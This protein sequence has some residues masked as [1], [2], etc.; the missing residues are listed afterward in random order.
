MREITWIS[1]GTCLPF[2]QQWN[3][4][5]GASSRTPKYGC[6]RIFHVH[7]DIAIILIHLCICLQWHSKKSSLSITGLVCALEWDSFNINPLKLNREEEQ[8]AQRRKTTRHARI[9]QYLLLQFLSLAW[10][11]ES[12]T[13]PSF[14]SNQSEWDGMDSTP[15]WQNWA[16]PNPDKLQC[17]LQISYGFLDLWIH[18]DYK[19]QQVLTRQIHRQAICYF[20][21]LLWKQEEYMKMLHANRKLNNAFI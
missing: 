5:V 20:L 12:G 13:E 6:E 17:F 3:S 1:K 8:K 15:T 11:T 10:I 2:Q 4:S 19:W 14:C 21:F 16:S 18:W 9:S 7:F